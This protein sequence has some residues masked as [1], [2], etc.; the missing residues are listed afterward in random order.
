LARDFPGLTFVLE[1]AGMLEDTSLDGRSRSHD[2]MEQLAACPNVN[3]K[4]SELGTC[5]RR[6]RRSDVAIGFGD[7]ADIQR[8]SLLIWKQFSDRETLD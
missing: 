7:R 8:G 4:L 2:G 6:H 3:V 5:A 1:H